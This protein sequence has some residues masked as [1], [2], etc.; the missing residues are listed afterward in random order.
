M[1]KNE[2]QLSGWSFHCTFAILWRIALARCALEVGVGG[3]FFRPRI[4][5]A[6]KSRAERKQSVSARGKRVA[7][8]NLI[9][10]REREG[11]AQNVKRI[12]FQACS[13][14]TVSSVRRNF[15]VQFCEKADKNRFSSA[16]S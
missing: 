5:R 1:Y 16:A 11:T 2:L 15:G 4:V 9:A 14:P 7:D 12:K 8:N 3:E 6:R 13:R 10:K